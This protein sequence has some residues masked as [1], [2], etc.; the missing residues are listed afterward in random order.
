MEQIPFATEQKTR[1]RQRCGNYWIVKLLGRGGFGTVYLGMHQHLDT[2]AAIKFLH[3]H[4]VGSEREQFL[5]EARLAAR[6]VHPHINRVLDYDISADGVPYLVMDYAGHGSLRTLYPKGRTLPLSAI[7]YYAE[8]TAEGLHYMHQRGLIH[9]DIKPE[10]LLV[11]RNHQVQISDFG[12]A[13]LARDVGD[14]ASSIIAGTPAYMAPEQMRGEPCCASDQYALA[15]VIYEW[16]CGTTP[17]GDSWHANAW[18]HLQGTPPPSLRAQGVPISRAIE[19]A[20]MRALAKEPEERYN[21]VLEFIAALKQAAARQTRAVNPL[22]ERATV[23]QG[24]S[25]RRAKSTAGQTSS[26]HR[27]RKAPRW[28]DAAALLGIDLLLAAIMGLICIMRPAEASLFIFPFCCLLTGF[29]FAGAFAIRHRRAAGIVGCIF[30]VSLLSCLALFSFA[31]Y[32][33]VFTIL[34]GVSMLIT[35]RLSRAGRRRLP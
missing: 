26:L 27:K 15:I 33:G 32:L 31:A 5:I 4:R 23:R 29:S 10:N 16:L 30:S 35:Y 12:V 9:Q 28:G 2:P 18:H 20:L 17:F 24:L 21:D 11:G 22:S 25:A 1:S 34:L 6:L 19:E 14:S 3:T 13:I 7:I 8:Q